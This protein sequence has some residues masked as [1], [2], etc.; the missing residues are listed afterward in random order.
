MFRF[1]PVFFSIL[2]AGCAHTSTL[3]SNTFMR[4]SQPVSEMK[5]LYLENTLTSAG[6]GAAADFSAYGY[7]DLPELLRE[8]ISV[9]FKLNNI[10]AD[11]A[12]FRKQYFGQQQAIDSIKWAST[13]NPYSPLLIIEIVGGSVVSGQRTPTTIT[14][15]MN[16]NLIDA[17]T[18]LRM[19]TGQFASRFMQPPVT[20][21]GF[22]NKSTDSLLK[23]ILE[24]M[25]K[26]GIIS[27]RGGQVVMPAL[28]N[29][30]SQG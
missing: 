10:H 5:V 3:Y 2:L 1:L 22:D 28:K 15:N 25:D 7:N 8:R 17:K 29:G 27:L 4:P 23:I 26:D 24:Q 20:H 6:T 12:T 9:V 14:L 19:W 16:A 18:K 11:Y 30:N 13:D 21:V